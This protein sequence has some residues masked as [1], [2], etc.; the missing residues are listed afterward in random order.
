[1]SVLPSIMRVVESK[2]EK[3]GVKAREQGRVGT[4]EPNPS[5]LFALSTVPVA[6]AS[7]S[8]SEL[9]EEKSRGEYEDVE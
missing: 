6:E 8:S 4:H 7:G 9:D 1:M 2:V 5:S 3:K